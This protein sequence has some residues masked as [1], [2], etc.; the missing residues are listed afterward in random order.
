MTT[1]RTLRFSAARSS[2]LARAAISPT[3]SALRCA[4]RFRVSRKTPR[5]SASSNTGSFS[6]TRAVA[7]MF[8]SVP[9]RPDFYLR[10]PA[11]A[12]TH[13]S[14]RS[15]A[16]GWVPA[17]AGTRNLGAIWVH[18]VHRSR[19]RGGAHF[20][21]AL[22]EI[23]DQI[24]RVFEPDMDAHQGP[25]RLPPRRGAAALRE[26]GLDQALIPAPAGAD[27]E[28]IERVDE[29]GDR[30]LRRRLQHHPEQTAGPEEIAFPQLVAGVFLQRRV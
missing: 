27:A 24:L 14:T 7:C 25:F 26:G 9:Q 12:G 1:T 29:G 15:E 10:V 13:F 4:G 5:S 22:G 8:A 19:R 11:K 16:D 6:A 2:A 20:V 23:G 28:Q 18:P 30:L 17:S 3:D 21:E